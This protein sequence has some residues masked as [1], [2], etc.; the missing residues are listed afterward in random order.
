MDKLLVI[1]NNGQIA[2]SIAKIAHQYSSLDI[3]YS[4]RSQLDLADP[5]SIANYFDRDRFDVVINSAAYTAVDQAESEQALVERINH[6]AVQQ[7]AEIARQQQFILIQVSTDYV[8]DSAKNTPYLEGDPTH[9]TSIYGKSKRSGEEAI[10]AIVPMGCI[11]R[12]SWLYSEFGQNFVK[13]MLRLGKERDQLNVVYDQIGSPTYATDFA[14]VLLTIA[15]SETIQLP[16]ETTPI[17]HYTNQGLAS[18][19]DLAIAIFELTQTDCNVRPI[20]SE[21]YPTTAKRPHYSV[22]NTEK[23]EQQF[24][25]TIPY[26]RDSLRNCLKQLCL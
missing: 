25:I 1:G 19:Y 10:E 15:T 3:S 13:T 24:H 7:L 16:Q 11:V 4:D 20:T 6:H 18:W 12:T 5:T 23:V 2:Q 26:W 17:Y 8:F 21:K 14:H 22:L 9:P